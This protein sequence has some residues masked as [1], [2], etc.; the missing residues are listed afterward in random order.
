MSSTILAAEPQTAT[1]PLTK[2]RTR[3]LLRMWAKK[4]IE[5]RPFKL[6][7]VSISRDADSRGAFAAVTP[8]NGDINL[9]RDLPCDKAL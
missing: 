1:V 4:L 9:D 8:A 3:I 6:V 5:K 2:H 7:A